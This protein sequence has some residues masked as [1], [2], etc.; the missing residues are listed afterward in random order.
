MKK[1]FICFYFLKNLIKKLFYFFID[2]I[3]NH[4][5]ETELSFKHNSLI[6]QT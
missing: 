4:L 2:F 3:E 6:S 1:L 5:R